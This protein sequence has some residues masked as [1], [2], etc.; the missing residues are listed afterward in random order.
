MTQIAL[1]LIPGSPGPARIV[2]GAAN[3]HVAE[4]LSHPET[5]PFRTAVL[6]GPPRSGKSLLAKWFVDS[7]PGEERREAID[8]A[9]T[10]DEIDLFHRWNRAQERGTPLLIVAGE[11]PWDIAL[12]DLRSR[13]GAA[14]QLEIGAPDDAMAHELLY[15][16]AEQRG[17]PL[18]GDA[19]GYLV[20]RAGR[21]FADIEKLVAAIDRLSLER[22]APPTQSI[23]RAALEAI[24]GPEEPRLL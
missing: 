2:I 17:L 21:S 12:P 18:A 1:P 22:K 24:D 9:Q 14:L 20:S 6:T 5:W 4:A 8:D 13:L 15:A 10:L 11:P 7:G 19:A 23:W 3:A 16:I